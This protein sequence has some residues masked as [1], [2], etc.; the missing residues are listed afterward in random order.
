VQN[1]YLLLVEN[2]LEFLATLW[3][4]IL[5]VAICFY[6]IYL[7]YFRTYEVELRKVF[8]EKGLIYVDSG[9]NPSFCRKY[10]AKHLEFFF[11]NMSY[12]IYVYR[13]VKF[14]DKEGY[15]FESCA[16]LQLNL[17]SKINKILWKP[18]LEELYAKRG[19]EQNNV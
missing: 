3:I 4:I 15:S 16:E 13:Y 8:T 10:F 18:T 19:R 7:K 6:Y 14:I 12:N 9:R 2:K 11:W 1:F 17:L 5:I